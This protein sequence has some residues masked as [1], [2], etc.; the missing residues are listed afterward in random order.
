[1]EMFNGP[2]EAFLHLAYSEMSD[3]CQYDFGFETGEKQRLTTWPNF[4]GKFENLK[5]EK[6]KQL[7]KK[8]CPMT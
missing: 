8:Q 3:R 6:Q 5:Q 2:E 1:M 4:K 7:P